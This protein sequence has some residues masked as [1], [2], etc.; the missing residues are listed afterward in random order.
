MTFYEIYI[1][2][3]DLKPCDHERESNPYLSSQK[4]FSQDLTRKL[5]TNFRVKM[6]SI[7][8][9]R[10]RLFKTLPLNDMKLEIISIQN[11][12]KKSFEKCVLNKMNIF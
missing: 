10:I 1:L 11:V 9:Y 6:Q 7:P 5:T 12:E 2:K 8:C 3:L 4:S